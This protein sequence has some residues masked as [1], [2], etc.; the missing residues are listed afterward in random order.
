MIGT[1]G[2]TKATKSFSAAALAEYVAEYIDAGGKDATVL[3][4]V[5]KIEIEDNDLTA[6][7]V[8][9]FIAGIQDGPVTGTVVIADATTGFYRNDI[10]VVD[11]SGILFLINGIESEIAAVTPALP[12][13]FVL[14]TEVNVFGSEMNIQVPTLNGWKNYQNLTFLKRK[15]NF[16]PEIIQGGDPVWGIMSDGITLIQGAPYLGTGS[17]FDVANYYSNPTDISE[18]PATNTP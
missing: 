2:D 4:S 10:L 14:V 11:K 6:T 16:K 9:Y 15:G 1:D 18:V 7:N 8:I 13:G 5:E 12:V 17:Y 3:I